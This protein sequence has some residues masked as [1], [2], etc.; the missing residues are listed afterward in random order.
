VRTIIAVVAV[1]VAAAACDNSPGAPSF[2]PIFAPQSPPASNPPSIAGTYVMTL[3]AP[4]GCERLP[5]YAKTRTYEAAVSQDEGATRAT[6]R[7]RA[8]EPS[9]AKECRAT[10]RVIFVR[11]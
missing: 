2:R 4:A 6:V 1:L 8:G 9:T 3:S 10:H 5:D 7:L 11:K